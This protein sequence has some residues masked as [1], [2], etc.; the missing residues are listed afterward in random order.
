MADVRTSIVIPAFNRAWCIRDAM[1]SALAAMAAEDEIIAVDDGSTD[2]TLAILNEYAHRR[3]QQVRVLRH[4]DGANR[5]I[6]AT[7]NLG[8]IAARGEYVAFL[9][10][11]DL[12][13]PGRLADAPAWLDRHLEMLAGIE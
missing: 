8:I 7:R 5:G 12:F 13:E 11:D 3:P 6:A 9:D 1:E 10:S 2:G 4:P